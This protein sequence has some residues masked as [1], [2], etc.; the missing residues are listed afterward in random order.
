MLD[1]LEAALW[2]LL[3]TDSYKECV[4]KAVNLGED[5]DTTAAVAG[6]LAGALYGLGGIPAEWL[7]MLQRRELIEKIC[8]AFSESVC[9]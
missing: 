7:A 1:T 3:T 2:C 5:T 8:E 6:A 9:Q 4:L